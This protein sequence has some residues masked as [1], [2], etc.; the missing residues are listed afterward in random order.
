MS[1][2]IL[3]AANLFVGDDDPTNG[4]FITL[5]SLKLPA[6][7]E[8]TKDHTGGGAAMGIQMGMRMLEPLE[9][10]FKLEGVNIRTMTKFMPPDRTNYTVRGNI[11]DLDLLTDIPVVAVIAGRMSSVDMGEYGRDNGTETDYMISEVVRYRLT[12][13]DVEKYRFD[14]FR[15]MAGV[16]VDGQPLFGNVARNLGLL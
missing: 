14:Y 10:T 3:D 2:M 7:K 12:I 1:L 11:R 16:F 15:G 5:K 9:F 4:E 8:K 13:G 6:L